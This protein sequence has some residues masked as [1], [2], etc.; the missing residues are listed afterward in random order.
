MILISRHCHEFRFWEGKR[1]V[2]SLITDICTGR[3]GSPLL[4]TPGRDVQHMDTGLV[5]M[6]RVEDD[7]SIIIDLIVCQFDFVEGDNLLHPVTA[8]GRRIGVNMYPGRSDWV[9]FSCHN[10]R[11]AVDETGENVSQ[12]WVG[13]SR[14]DLENE[15]VQ[16]HSYMIDEQHL[17]L[18]TAATDHDTR[19]PPLAHL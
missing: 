9:R 10:P 13:D 17:L 15:L 14:N 16:S 12:G 2:S 11:R 8:S 19:T 4:L 18:I 6:H 1:F 5:A 3:R 7:V